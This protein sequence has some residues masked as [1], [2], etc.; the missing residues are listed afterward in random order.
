MDSRA[1]DTTARLKTKVRKKRKGRAAPAPAPPSEFQR[2]FC[3]QNNSCWLDS[4]LTVLFAEASHGRIFPDLQA[5][6][7]A[8]PSKHLLH[9]V[10]SII[11]KHIAQAALPGF[12]DGGCKPLTNMRNQFRKSLSKKNS[13]NL[14]APQMQYL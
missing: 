5:T 4:S 7:A 13:L 11:G 14:T 1:P 9:G 2:S 3:W 10:L 6:F 12:D 8:L